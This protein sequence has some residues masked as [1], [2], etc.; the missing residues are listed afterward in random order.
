MYSYNCPKC[1]REFVS[2]QKKRKYCSIK[3][4]CDARNDGIRKKQTKIC[5]CCKLEKD[6]SSFSFKSKERGTLRFECKECHSKKLKNKP[7]DWKEKEK[8]RSRKKSR[9]KLGL[10]VNFKG[11]YKY[12]VDEKTRYISDNGYVMIYRK[13][14]PNSYSRGRIAEH[15]WIMSE[16]LGRP[17]R[18]KENVHHKNGIRDDNRIENLELWS[19]NQPPGQRVEDKIAW[20]KEFLDQYGYDVTKR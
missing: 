15:I 1:E 18:E 17:L 16:H 13:N 9:K 20:C 12:P 5:C 6:V 7:I 4:A 3:C 2:Q 14:H 11:L 10:D 8:I 19:K